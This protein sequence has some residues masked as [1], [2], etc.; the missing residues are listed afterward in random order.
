[1]AVIL[2]FTIPYQNTRPEL[3]NPLVAITTTGINRNTIVPAL[4]QLWYSRYPGSS[5]LRAEFLILQSARLFRTLRQAFQRRLND[6][7]V[8]T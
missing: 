6:K 2:L 7:C 3:F 5:V 1:M 8:P 4:T